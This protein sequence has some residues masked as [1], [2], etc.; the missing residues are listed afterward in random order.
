MCKREKKMYKSNITISTQQYK[1]KPKAQQ[2]RCRRQRTRIPSIPEST[3]NKS[4]I[5]Y[6][7]E[8]YNKQHKIS[9]IFKLMEKAAE[10]GGIEW[11]SL[12]HVV[13]L[14]AKLFVVFV[15]RAKELFYYTNFIKGTN[16]LLIERKSR[17]EWSRALSWAVGVYQTKLRTSVKN[18]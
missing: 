12:A 13:Y 3:R 14:H 10:A 8:Q 5:I 9:I 16:T 7:H 15:R 18:I 1:K 6:K 2:Q 4:I 17:A 11:V